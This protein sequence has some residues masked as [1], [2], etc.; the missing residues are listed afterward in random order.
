[1]MTKKENLK[2]TGGKR[3]QVVKKQSWFKIPKPANVVQ[4]CRKFSARKHGRI[5]RHRA[6]KTPMNIFVASPT[7]F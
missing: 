7:A 6:K 2:E 5:V 4:D 3:F 1:M